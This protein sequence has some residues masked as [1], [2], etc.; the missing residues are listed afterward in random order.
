MT[1]AFDINSFVRSTEGSLRLWIR[2]SGMLNFLSA[3]RTSDNVFATV[4]TLFGWGA[5]MTA[6]QLLTENIV[7]LMKFVTG[8]VIGRIAATTPIG[9][10]ISTSPVSLS[11]LT[12]PTDFF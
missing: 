8:I 4:L 9:L 7:L 10:A 2:F 5:A 1:S 3:A 12:I 6:L 11:R